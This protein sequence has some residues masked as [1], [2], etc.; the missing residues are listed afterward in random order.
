MRVKRRVGRKK[1]VLLHREVSDDG[2]L[3][4][5]A[6]FVELILPTRIHILTDRVI[7]EMT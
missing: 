1:N 7:N 5:V 6:T 3:L 4:A 2:R